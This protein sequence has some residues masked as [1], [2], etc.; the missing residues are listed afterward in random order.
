[1]GRPVQVSLVGSWT[2]GLALRLTAR[3]ELFATFA[4]RLKAVPYPIF[5]ILS[6]P[7]CTWFESDPEPCVPTSREGGEKWGTRGEPPSSLPLLLFFTIR[8]RT[9]A[10]NCLGVML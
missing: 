9:Q 4:A 6:H 5:S 1:V 3:V 2:S 7:V 8:A 10:S